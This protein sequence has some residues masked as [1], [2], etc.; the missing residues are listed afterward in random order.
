MSAG[1]DGEAVVTARKRCG[2][3][4]LRKSATSCMKKVFFLKLEKVVYMSYERTANLSG[5][6]IW[7]FREKK[8]A[9]M[10]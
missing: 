8:I 10:I 5:C 6:K 3:V 7:W 1:G 4:K 2:W 9:K